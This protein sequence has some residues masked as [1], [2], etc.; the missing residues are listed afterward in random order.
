MSTP[1]ASWERRSA[2][3]PAA[4]RQ[5]GNALLALLSVGWVALVIF[6]SVQQF[7][8]PAPLS[9]AVSDDRFSAT[10]A[11]RHV[12]ELAKAPR[13]PGSQGAIRALQYLQQELSTLG[14]STATI[15]GTVVRRNLAAKVVNLAATL[16]A[17]NPTDPALFLV[18]HYDSVSNGPG[19]GDDASGVAVVLE[20]IRALK[21][22]GPHRRTIVALFTD[23][24][25]PGLLGARLFAERAR[26][27]KEVGVVLNFEA[28]GTRG[29]ALIFETSGAHGELLR[30]AAEHA[31]ACLAG[32]VSNDA[33][34]LMPNDTDL[35][36]FK[37]RNISGL[38][39]SF[40]DGLVYYHSAQDTPEML[41][42][43]SLQM[44]G[45]CAVALARALAGHEL[46]DS[47]RDRVTYF[48]VAGLPPVVYSQRFAYVAAFL[49]ALALLAAVIRAA[50]QRRIQVGKT[51]LAFV[52]GG[53]AIAGITMA[54]RIMWQLLLAVNPYY[55]SFPDET[56]H[57]WIF[58][59]ALTAFAVAAFSALHTVARRFLNA[60]DVWAGTLILC[61]VLNIV[62]LTVA[63]NSTY[64]L[65]WPIV[66]GVIAFVASAVDGGF[67]SRNAIV[68][69]LAAA[70]PLLLLAP[71]TQ[72]FFY[73]M[74]LGSIQFPVALALILLCLLIPQM[75]AIRKW[76]PWLLPVCAAAAVVTFCVAGN[77]VVRPS[78]DQKQPDS[79]FYASCPGCG[80]A[81]WGT[82]DPGVDSWTAQFLG[83]QPPSGP[84]SAYLPG[85]T[86]NCLYTAAPVADV[87]PPAITLLGRELGE[88]SSILNFTLASRRQAERL[89]IE[90]EPESA[91]LSSEINAIPVQGRRSNGRYTILYQ[92]NTDSVSLRCETTAGL[93]VTLRVTDLSRGLP[94]LPGSPLPRRPEH[95]SSSND[96]WSDA[97][98]ATS[99]AQF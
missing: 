32:S 92:G 95:L 69:L 58:W 25:E 51:A 37:S 11:Y 82:L 7:R 60:G 26:L 80:G 93:P 99:V 13:P 55:R 59:S 44:E 21:A 84:C 78:S 61:C 41:D 71:T 9:D 54:S 2:Q 81:V 57:A 18:A 66:A 89:F 72:L 76:C 3:N 90:V 34:D 15:E 75:E 67:S 79:L 4:I 24:E 45:N 27:E 35:T 73:A 39:F 14:M 70:V 42:L 5:Y 77:L 33:Y 23:A 68:A 88:S 28:R 10:R 83:K 97:L 6:L 20:T 50:A 53:L 47:R 87:A 91:V 52:G 86:R 40:F 1:H 98:L 16:P 63:P 17:A 30:I 43:G 19:A 65:T 29:P 74:S 31:P 62:L 56:Y 22:T 49:T 38:N 85:S 12:V 8:L 48:R 46:S 64:L 96:L 36:V 94:H